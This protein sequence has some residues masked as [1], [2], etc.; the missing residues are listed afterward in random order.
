MLLLN[1][2]VERLGS[3]NSN[4]VTKQQCCKKGREDLTAMLLLNSNVVT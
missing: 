4:I 3:P 1:S 2:S